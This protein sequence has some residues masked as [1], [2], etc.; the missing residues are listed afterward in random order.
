MRS[1]LLFGVVAAATLLVSS[2]VDAAG[3]PALKRIMILMNAQASAGNARGMQMAFIQTR[4]WAKPDE[5]PNWATY[6]EKGRIA[7]HNG[8]LAGAK[9]VC[10]ECH[11]AYREQFRNKYGSKAGG[12]KDDDKLP[13]KID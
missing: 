8:N 13:K 12:G 10:T 6:A 1:L 3:N 7:A 2:D 9:A 11:D 4:A 5:F